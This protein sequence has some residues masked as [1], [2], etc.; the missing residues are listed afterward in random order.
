MFKKIVV[1]L[2]G[3]KASEAGLRLACDM[4]QKYEAKLHL[5]HTP[6]MEAV[7]YAAMA[8]CMVTVTPVQ[9]ELDAAGERVLEAGEAM[10]KDCG[11]SAVETHLTHGNA[12]DGV[13]ECAEKYGADLIITGR[14]GLGRV[15]C[16]L[17]G[18]T[19]QRISH[20]SKCAYM[21]VVCPT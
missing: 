16:L 8:P 14:R 20:L 13:L 4:A 7:A 21:S 1:G 2:D 9:N 15:A 12:A 18:S 5:V 6:Q 10:A 11:L 17:L 19:S 3:S